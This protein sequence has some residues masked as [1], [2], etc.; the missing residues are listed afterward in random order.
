M[1][2]E[3]AYHK[4]I[5]ALITRHRGAYSGAEFQQAITDIIP[6]LG[7]V[8]NLFILDG[9][10]VDQADMYDSDRAKVAFTI[11]NLEVSTPGMVKQSLID[12][13]YIAMIQSGSELHIRVNKM[14]EENGIIRN[15]SMAKD[16]A[17]VED[18][19]GIHFT[20]PW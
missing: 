1:L 8:P 11:R 2:V 5:N 3:W 14:F 20:P 7:V 13:S 6:S 16:W 15:I 4:E 10:E 12:V 17:T 18:L 19:I 9:R